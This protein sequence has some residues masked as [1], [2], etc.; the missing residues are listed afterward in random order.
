MPQIMFIVGQCLYFLASTSLSSSMAPV[1]KD[2]IPKTSLSAMMPLYVRMRRA[3][4]V[5]CGHT[6]LAE[7]RTTTELAAAPYTV[8]LLRAYR[9]L[10]ILSV[11][12]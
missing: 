10:D 8:V 2:V 11:P 5:L 12:I 3:I 9:T 7:I 4:R 1:F 6:F